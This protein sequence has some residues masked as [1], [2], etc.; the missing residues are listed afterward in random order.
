MGWN[1]MEWNGLVCTR[2]VR[3]VNVGAGMPHI[4]SQYICMYDWYGMPCYGV[5]CYGW[6]RHGMQWNELYVC[7]PARVS[8]CLYAY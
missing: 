5:L 1:L 4:Q 3:I 8:V 2:T 7:M 6:L